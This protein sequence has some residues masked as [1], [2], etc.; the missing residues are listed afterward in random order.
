MKKIKNLFS[1]DFEDWFNAYTDLRHILKT[2]QS[3]P[4]VYT[5]S[6]IEHGCN[7]ILEIIED[8]KI[9]STFFILGQVA[10]Q[11]KKLIRKI[12]SLGHEIGSHG[13]NHL[14]FI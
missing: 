7:N 5:N 1:V 8:K 6:I 9:K 14:P 11:N 3:R 2:S 10:Q 4:D 12:Y 13:Y